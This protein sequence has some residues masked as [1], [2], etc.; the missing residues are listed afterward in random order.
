MFTKGKWKVVGFLGEHDE[1]G[2]I[3][4]SGDKTIA[5]T[6]GGLRYHS[7]PEEW[8]EYHANANLIAASPDMY[9]ALK[10]IE[11]TVIFDGDKAIY[12]VDKNCQYLMNMAL[13]KADGK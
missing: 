3:I 4:K 2:A 7:K 10:A 1:M 12:T 5:H 8:G 13:A 6:V 11:A 9:K